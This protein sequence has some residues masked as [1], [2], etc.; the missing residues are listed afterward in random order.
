M[1][2]VFVQ[3]LVDQN[4]ESINHG[5]LLFGRGVVEAKFSHRPLA[6]A[7]AITQVKKQTRDGAEHAKYDDERR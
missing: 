7:V 3:Y 5:F 4:R 1:E 2:A 6:E